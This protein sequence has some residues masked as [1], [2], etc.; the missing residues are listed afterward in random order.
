M[1]AQVELWRVQ[2]AEGVFEADLPTLKLWIAEG[3]VLPT[4][5]V[6]KGS[7]NWIDAGRAPMLRAAFS[8]ERPVPVAVVNEPTATGEH[9]PA[10]PVVAP[11]YVAEAPKAANT[12]ACQ[13]HPDN[14]PSYLCTGCEALLCSDCPRVVSRTPL[15]PLCGELCKSYEEVKT[16]TQNRA[17][18][19]SGFGMADFG[20]AVSY[21]FQHK[22]ALAFGALLYAVLLLLG[23][24]AGVIAYVILFGCMSHV[25]S[26]VA[27]GRLNRSFMPDFSEFSVVDDLVQPICLGLGITI[28]TWGPTIV[29]LLALLFGVMQVVPDAASLTPAG[30]EAS[31]VSEDPTMDD[32]A[33]LTD[34][35]ADPKALE[36]ANR[37][38]NQTRPGAQISREAERSQEELNDPAAGLS[39]LLPYLG[40]G[41]AVMLLLIVC[42]V[43]AIFYYPMALAVAGYTQSFGSVINPLVGLDTI[44]RMGSTYFKAFG[45]VLGIQLVGFG[46]SVVVAHITAPLTLPFIGNL[47]ATFIN[48][49]VTFYFNLV[50]ACLLGLSLYKCADRLGISVD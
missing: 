50:V 37:K 7:L 27:W 34:P 1:S 18:Q 29:L 3:A 42:L 46:V 4:D 33:V 12:N 21:P 19:A 40:A 9:Y 22:V 48:G 26:Q 10:D 11:S 15:C 31:Q 24:R 32:L 47:P 45:M 13:V 30:T 44:K 8:G 20:R 14:S 5:K 39:M 6:S 23:W 2:T 41:I 28:V 17:F 16:R 43:W 36:E 49:T 25:I 35:N 38:L